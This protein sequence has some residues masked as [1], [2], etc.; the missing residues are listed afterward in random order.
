M[1]GSALP[2]VGKML[3]LYVYLIVVANT[4]QICAHLLFS[5]QIHKILVYKYVFELS[6]GW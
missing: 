6:P 5:I 4:D 3:I 2:F 1:S